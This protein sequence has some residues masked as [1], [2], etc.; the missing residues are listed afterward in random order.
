[1]A[2]KGATMSTVKEKP[3]MGDNT[4][5][6]LFQVETTGGRDIFLTPE[7]AWKK[8]SYEFA[9][10]LSEN[11]VDRTS[12]NFVSELTFLSSLPINAGK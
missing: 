5:M 11:I 12:P 6:H 2:S 1:M 7:N 4:R 9:P 10:I 3:R 8:N